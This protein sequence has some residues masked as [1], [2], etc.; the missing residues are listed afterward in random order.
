MTRQT[1]DPE[2]RKR[3]FTETAERLFKE[4]GFENTTVDDIVRTMDVAKGLFYYYFKTKEEVLYDIVNYRIQRIMDDVDALMS[5]PFGSAIE[6]LKALLLMGGAFAH[7]SAKVNSYFSENRNKE[8]SNYYERQVKFLA[9]PYIIEVLEKGAEEGA[10]SIEYIPETADAIMSLR[11]PIFAT[12]DDGNY[13]EDTSI[14]V[15]LCERLLGTEPG[16]L[17]CRWLSL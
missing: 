4:K 15:Y 9:R 13:T 2:E 12:D 11:I 8:F 3:E 6:M 1:K 10:F 17:R 14:K 16:I 7:S 5:K